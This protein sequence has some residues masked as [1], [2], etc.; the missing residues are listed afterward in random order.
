MTPKTLA[1]RIAHLALTKKANDVTILDLRKLTDMTDFFVICSADSDIQVKAV[2]D[3]ISEGTEKF[4][5]APWHSEGMTQRQWIL[6]DYVDVVV[7]IFHREA[8][9][10]YAL[11]KLWGDAKAETVEDL[12]VRKPAV[13]KRKAS[14]AS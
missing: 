2:S 1:N 13:R 4:G 10:Y 12:P 9:R 3:A 7:H 14:R 6:M 5:A 11:E 8:R